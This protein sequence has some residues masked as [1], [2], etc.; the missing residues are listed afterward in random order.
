MIENWKQVL[1]SVD[2]AVSDQGRVRRSTPGLRTFVGRIHSV[3]LM[4]KYLY[5]SFDSYG[6]KKY[7][8]IH[9]LVLETF[10]GPAPVGHECNHKDSNCLNNCVD[11]LE[12]IP[13]SENRSHKGSKNG[14][15]KLK[16][17]E[18]WLIKKILAA[19]VVGKG[20]LITFRFLDAM[21]KMGKGNAAKIKRGL[22][23]RHVTI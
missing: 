17:G 15:S 8:P 16:E 4:G 11:N 9:R 5:I 1:H 21:F 19:D 6:P 7:F 12:W 2:Y 14:S 18:V 20:K 23:W 3:S 10:V 22:K 13:I